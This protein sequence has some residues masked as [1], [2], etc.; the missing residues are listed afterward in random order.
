MLWVFS[1]SRNLIVLSIWVRSQTVEGSFVMRESLRRP[2]AIR[3]EASSRRLV[4]V[5]PNRWHI[6]VERVSDFLRFPILR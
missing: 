4:S 1:S 3:S 5:F 6:L 2:S